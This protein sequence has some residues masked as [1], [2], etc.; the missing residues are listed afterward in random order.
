M[1]IKLGFAFRPKYRRVCGNLEINAKLD[2]LKVHL[3]YNAVLYKFLNCSCR[4]IITTFIGFVIINDKYR[5]LCEA[6]LG[7]NDQPASCSTYSS[8]LYGIMQYAVPS[9]LPVLLKVNAS[10]TGTVSGRCT[11][12][13]EL[14]AVL[15]RLLKS[16]LHLQ[17]LLVTCTCLQA[18]SLPAKQWVLVGV[19]ICTARRHISYAAFIEM[20]HCI[21]SF[22]RLECQQGTY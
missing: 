18:G 21:V 8:K 11:S 12:H 22:A 16:N 19:A 13:K 20:Y 17:K 4:Q 6:P 9:Q 2:I 14:L 3:I 10:R 15:L 5:V 7:F 1:V